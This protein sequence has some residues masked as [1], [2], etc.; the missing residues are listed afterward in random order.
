MNRWN[1]SYRVKSFELRAMRMC[2]ELEQNQKLCENSESH[3]RELVDGSDPAYKEIG[4]RNLRI[5]PRKLVDCS[6]PASETRRAEHIQ[7]RPQCHGA[8][9]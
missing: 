7:E 6:D 2:Q 3:Q 8:S 5:P 4:F 1:H 9:P